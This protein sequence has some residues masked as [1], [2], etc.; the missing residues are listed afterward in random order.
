MKFFLAIVALVGF[1]SSSEVEDLEACKLF[2]QCAHKAMDG[3]VPSIPI[4]NHNPLQ[5]QDVIYGNTAYAA[6]VT[7]NVLYNLTDFA[8]TQLNATTY[9]NPGRVAYYYNVYW[10]QLNFTGEFDIAI[11]T[12]FF[13][14]RFHGTYNIDMR[15]INWR[16]IFNLTKPGQEGVKEHLDDFTLKSKAKSVKVTFQGINGILALA[17]ETSFTSAI[18]ILMNNFPEDAAVF[19]KEQRFNGFW[20]ANP[21]KIDQLIAFCNQ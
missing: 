13:P 16:G 5:I 20:L 1:A 7:N 4:P 19:L 6:N 12:K 3:G 14:L 15:E 17:L 9:E 8:V 11:Y 21:D 18:G 2:L 10:P